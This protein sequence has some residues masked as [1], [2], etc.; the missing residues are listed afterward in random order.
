[1]SPIHT[2]TGLMNCGMFPKALQASTI[3]AIW[4]LPQNKHDVLIY[5]IVRVKVPGI[6]ATTHQVTQYPLKG[7]LFPEGIESFRVDDVEDEELSKTRIYD[8][9]G[10]TLTACATQ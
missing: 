6:E 8:G 3:G 5:A 10:M 4:T 1:V 2:S 9:N 7:H